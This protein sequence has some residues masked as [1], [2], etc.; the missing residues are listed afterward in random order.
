MADHKR[1]PYIFYNG[2]TYTTHVNF[3][4]F[5]AR[6]SCYEAVADSPILQCYVDFTHNET[7]VKKVT[8]LNHGGNFCYSLLS[9]CLCYVIGSI[10]SVLNEGHGRHMN[11]PLHVYKE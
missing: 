6:L 4:E 1:L 11:P 10:N 9:M 3:K 8:H 5:A 2:I 7:Y